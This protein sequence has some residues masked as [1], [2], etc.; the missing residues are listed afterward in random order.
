MPGPYNTH[1]IVNVFRSIVQLVSSNPELL[2]TPGVFRVAAAKEETQRL[3]DQF[4]SEQFDMGLL[5]HYVMEQNKVDSERFHNILGMIPAVFKESPILDSADS[6]LSI[7]SQRLKSLFK[8]QKE[9][10]LIKATELFDK[11]ICDL[12]LSKRI[13]HQRAGE[14]LD[15]Y[16]YL[17]HQA[18]T[19][20]DTNLMTYNNLA[21]IM[22]PRLTEVLDLFHET[23]FLGLSG[24]ISQLT[25]VLEHYITDEKWNYD[26]KERH[27]DK[28]EHLAS[29]RHSILE[30]LEHM[31]EAFRDA[32]TVPMKSLMLQAATL[33][34]QIEAIEK[35]LQNH[36]LKRKAKKELTKQLKQLKAEMNELNLRISELTP[37]ISTMNDGCQ[38]IQEEINHLSFSG[39]GIRT[40]RDNRGEKSSDSN[41]T[42]LSIFESGKSTNTSTILS[43]IPE[44]EE[45]DYE[46]QHTANLGGPK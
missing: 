4:I 38:K 12:L 30:Q 7:F 40:V 43:P 26:F 24:F 46:N 42:R 16:C 13:E 32:V 2:N 29:T 41:L 28:L 34:A 31:K 5:S 25:P 23:D 6:Q 8:P 37:K 36:S 10:N 44:E 1:V 39:D 20:Q 27:T 35:Q 21:I 15:H 14:I 18:G 11:F 19:F 45:T 22:A 33:K 3:L 17:M 9:E